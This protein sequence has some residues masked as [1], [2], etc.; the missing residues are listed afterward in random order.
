[1]ENKTKIT[2]NNKTEGNTNVTIEN[3]F[4]S[5]P[6]NMSD[7][8]TFSS[9]T[10]DLCEMD[11]WENYTWKCAHCGQPMNSLEELRSHSK[12]KHS[13]CHAFICADCNETFIIFEQFVD[14]VQKH[15][16]GLR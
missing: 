10:F 1:M 9:E 5:K 14:H 13:M 7:P 3:Q 16:D 15:R 6:G 4:E 12:E 8:V 11:T 2:T